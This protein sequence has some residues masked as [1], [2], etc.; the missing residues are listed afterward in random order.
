MSRRWPIRS[1][2][3]QS[4]DT[5]NTPCSI[6]GYGI[7]LGRTRGEQLTLN[8]ELDLNQKPWRC[9]ATATNLLY[10]HSS[11]QLHLSFF[12]AEHAVWFFRFSAPPTCFRLV[13]QSHLYEWSLLVFRVTRKIIGRITSFVEGWTTVSF[14]APWR[15]QGMTLQ[16]KP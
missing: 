13:W 7:S 1:T 2:P 3:R 12:L 5:S 4:R 6:Q 16:W 10:I 14:D 8:K 11:V 9:E 15:Q